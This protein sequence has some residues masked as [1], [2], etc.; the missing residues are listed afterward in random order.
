MS[1][2]VP[3]FIT[4]GGY[5]KLGMQE[6]KVVDYYFTASDAPFVPN[7]DKLILVLEGG[8]KID[9]TDVR[10]ATKSKKRKTKKYFPLG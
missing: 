3:D 8:R 6:V 4:K 2:H 9:A 7:T 5:V 1:G 10:P